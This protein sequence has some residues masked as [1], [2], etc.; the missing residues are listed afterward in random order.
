[1]LD[2]DPS[3]LISHFFVLVTAFSVHEFAHAWTAN[4]FGDNTPRL[5]GRLTLNPLSHL[6]PIGSLL[7]LVAGFGWAKPVPVNPY[8]L[9]QRSPAALMWVSIAGPMSNLFLA[10]LAAIPFRLDVLSVFDAQF[11]LFT[12]SDHF[13]PTLPQLLYVFIYTNLLLMLFNLLPIAPLDGDK[14]ADYFFPPAWGRALEVIRPF[15]PLILLAVVF[16]GVLPY[17]ISPPLA[18]LM[19]LL[20]G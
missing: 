15:G 14:I 4:Y 1:M 8:A 16:L 20:V 3:T 11:A 17:I 5:H 19:G 6:D 9:R 10:I 12:S 2:L 13:L 18:L 7:L